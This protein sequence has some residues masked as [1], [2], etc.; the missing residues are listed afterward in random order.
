MSLI[1]GRARR[2]P[3][4]SSH[5]IDLRRFDPTKVEIELP[6]IPRSTVIDLGSS[7]YLATD[8]LTKET[9]TI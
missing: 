6:W 7:I 3:Q 4:E 2:H 9:L 8:L 1:H 5:T